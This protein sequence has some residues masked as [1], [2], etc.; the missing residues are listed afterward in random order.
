MRVVSPASEFSNGCRIIKQF[1]GTIHN[2]AGFA[3]RESECKGNSINPPMIPTAS[4]AGFAACDAFFFKSGLGLEVESD[5]RTVIETG[6]T[7]LVE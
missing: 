2:W 1:S 3:S 5:G 4:V 6:G 7:S